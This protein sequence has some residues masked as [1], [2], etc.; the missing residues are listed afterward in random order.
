MN[1]NLTSEMIGSTFEN[2]YINEKF[3][4]QRQNVCDFNPTL[5]MKVFHA[6]LFLIFETIGNFLLFCIII[7]EKYGMDSKKRTVTN[8]LL[9][10]ICVNNIVFNCIF[11]LITTIQRLF[12]IHGK[13]NLNHYIF[14]PS[15]LS[16]RPSVCT[17]RMST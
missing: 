11:M 13:L 16:V 5:E 12:D 3:T 8:Q 1:L 10:S 9:S 17:V 2:D 7:Y 6:I 14:Q 4:I 15:C